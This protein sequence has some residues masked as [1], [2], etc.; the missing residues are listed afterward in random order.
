MSAEAITSKCAERENS[1]DCLLRLLVATINEQSISED[2]KFDWD[3]I[4]FA[5]TVVVGFFAALFALVTIY[6]ATLAAGTGRRKCNRRAI[7]YWATKTKREWSWTELNRLSIATTPVLRA[8][9]VLEVLR[10]SEGSDTKFDTK[11]T[12]SGSAGSRAPAATWLRFLNHTGLEGFA[13]QCKQVEYTTADYLVSDLLAVPAY[14]DLGF[15]VAAAAASGGH[16]YQNDWDPVMAAYPVIEGA[17]FQFNF[18]QHPTLG[19]IGV[20]SRYGSDA[21]KSSGSTSS[22]ETAIDQLRFALECSLGELRYSKPPGF[23]SEKPVSSLI[24]RTVADGARGL[25][26]DDLRHR[27]SLHNRGFNSLPCLDFPWIGDGYGLRWMLET[28]TPSYVPVMFPGGPTR[29]KAFVIAKMALNGRFW[30]NPRAHKENSPQI[31]T[32]MKEFLPVRWSLDTAEGV[33]DSDLEVGKAA[34]KELRER[35]F[36][37]PKPAQDASFDLFDELLERTWLILRD[38][39]NFERLFTDSLDPMERKCFRIHILLHIHQLDRILAS[40]LTP[41]DLFARTCRIIHT[42][43]IFMSIDEALPNRGEGRPSWDDEDAREEPEQGSRTASPDIVQQN[44]RTLDVIQEILQDF[45]ELGYGDSP[46]PLDADFASQ[47]FRRFRIHRHSQQIVAFVRREAAPDN[48]DQLR[49]INNQFTVLRAFMDSI[50]G[51]KS[52]TDAFMD[53]DDVIIWRAILV[54]ALYWTAPDNSGTLRSGVWSHVVPI[55]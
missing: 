53:M 19:T 28:E 15:I 42:T 38:Y 30:S 55:I 11:G 34:L 27:P 17:E 39:D 22:D 2:A 4:T 16:S 8:K 14:A 29:R 44:Q 18:R 33:D 12:E 23:V 24:C 35:K 10:Q 51:E 31:V 49:L 26:D 32:P 47:I 1:T 7:G 5:F 36:L 21:T 48:I 46:P 13:R 9:D 41:E 43:L 6:Q 40:G 25:K 50:N 45:P 54:A 52:D 20:F 37:E 3:P